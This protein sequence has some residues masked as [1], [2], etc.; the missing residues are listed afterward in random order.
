MIVVTDLDGVILALTPDISYQRNGNPVVKGGSYAIS[1]TMVGGIYKDV[2]VPEGVGEETH[3][4]I[5]G[6][7]A[8]NPNY[9]PPEPSLEEQLADAVNAL[10]ILGYTEG[11]D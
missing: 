3:T 8:E 11:G 5:D 9:V 4:Y 2:D 6:V 1:A 7:F 10:K